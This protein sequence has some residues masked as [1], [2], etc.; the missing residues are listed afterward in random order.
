MIIWSGS[1][2]G[3]FNDGGQYNPTANGWTPVITSGAPAGR[4]SA[5]A[6]WTGN[7]MLIWGGGQGSRF[8]NDTYTY[9]PYKTAQVLYLYQKP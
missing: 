1:G 9:D 5:A 2:S 8:F 7:Q 3:N 4:P 6:A